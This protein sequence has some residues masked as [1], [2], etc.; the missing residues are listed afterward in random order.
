MPLVRIDAPHPGLRAIGTP[1]AFDLLGAIVSGLAD[2]SAEG[3]RKD[4]ASFAEFMGQPSAEAAIR[5]LFLLTPA[6]ANT[7]LL[8]WTDSMGSPHETDD[9]ACQAISEVARGLSPPEAGAA[10][11][12]SSPARASRP[13]TFASR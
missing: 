10:S 7:L 4:L 6:T 12:L 5:G 9:K 1:G 8:A 13:R 2:T 11:G 3:Y